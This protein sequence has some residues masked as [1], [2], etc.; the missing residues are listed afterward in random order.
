MDLLSLTPPLVLIIISP[1]VPVILVCEALCDRLVQSWL[2]K[3][4]L[5]KEGKQVLLGR[6]VI[7][8]LGSSMIVIVRFGP[9]FCQ[10]FFEIVWLT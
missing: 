10:K 6:R 3:H 1:M 8:L 2:H 9:L 7:I 4:T 5:N